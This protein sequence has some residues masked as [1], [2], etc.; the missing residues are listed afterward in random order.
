MN[1]PCVC[2]T[3][4]EPTE[5][6]LLDRPVLIVDDNAD[7]RVLVARILRLLGQQSVC[8]TGGSEALEYLRHEAQPKL[9]LLDLMMP[10]VDGFAVLRAIRSDPALSGLPVVVFSA[11][12]ERELGQALSS[13]ADDYLRKGSV[14]IEDIRDR[15]SRFA[16]RT[17]PHRTD[18]RSDSAGGS[19][20][21]ARIYCQTL[22]PARVYHH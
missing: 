21:G 7:V 8:A 19:L 13:G 22:T 16:G 6:V 14:N 1:W 20:A 15:L 18:G 5:G 10:D 11:A 17:K 4:A 12:G 9:V 2:L 3:S